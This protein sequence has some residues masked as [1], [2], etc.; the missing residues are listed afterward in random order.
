MDD[1]KFK[2]HYNNIFELVMHNVLKDKHD[3]SFSLEANMRPG[4]QLLSIPLGDKIST[5]FDTQDTANPKLEYY[6]SIETDFLTRKEIFEPPTAV[7]KINEDFKS[8][9]KYKSKINLVVKFNS[10]GTD[11]ELAWTLY[12]YKKACGNVIS[13]TYTNTAKTETFMDLPSTVEA[14]TGRA[15]D[16]GVVMPRDGLVCDTTIIPRRGEFKH[17]ELHSKIVNLHL[18]SQ[19]LPGV[20]GYNQKGQWG[21][22]LSGI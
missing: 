5:K 17:L 2:T 14:V 1:C 21:G 15:A 18:S 7:Q 11:Y 20:T 8:T 22:I 19:L 12:R 10:G 4:P 3:Q 6:L 13:F 16:A 9:K